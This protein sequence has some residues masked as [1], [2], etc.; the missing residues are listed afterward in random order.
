M[1]IENEA[2]KLKS[3]A[4]SILDGMFNIPE[5]CSSMAA[6]RFVECIISATLLTVAS[7][8]KEAIQTYKKLEVKDE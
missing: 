4:V 7:L 8:E 2:S 1:N 3:E 5:G 6:N